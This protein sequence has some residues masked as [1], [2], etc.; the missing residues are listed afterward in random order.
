[1]S[2]TWR[3][4]DTGL[5]VIALGLMGY[6]LLFDGSRWF[7]TAGLAIPAMTGLYLTRKERTLAREKERGV[8]GSSVLSCPDR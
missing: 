1:M 6:W 4:I 7:L 5:G 8:P 3:R 2:V